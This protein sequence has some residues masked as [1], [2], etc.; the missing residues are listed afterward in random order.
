MRPGNDPEKRGNT[1]LLS[2]C[3]AGRGSP[4]RCKDSC[5]LRGWTR[6][7][8][9]RPPDQPGDECL[10]ILDFLWPM[11]SFCW[12]SASR[13]GHR[14]QGGLHR[15]RHVL[16]GASDGAHN[17][18]GDRSGRHQDRDRGAGPGGA[19]ALRQ[20][21][22]DAERPI[23]ALLQLL[24]GAGCRRRSRLGDAR[25]SVGMAIPGSG[26]L[27]QRP[28]QERQL[29]LAER[30]A[31]AADLEAALGREVRLA[32]DANCFVLSE[33]TDGAAAGAASGVRRDRRHRR[34]RRRVW[35][36][37]RCWA[38]PMAWRGMGPN[39]CPRPAPKKWPRR[40]PAI[41]ASAAAWKLWCS[42]PGLAAD[43]MRMAAAEARRRRNRRPRMRPQRTRR[44]GALDWTV[45]PA[46]LRQWSI[47]WIPM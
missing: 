14:S 43:F 1:G 24:A 41:A 44:D 31:A 22:P 19:V 8:C 4:R 20:R 25:A 30:Q 26:K 27:R 47:F 42:G 39:P 28:D 6:P 2:P 3:L 38:A 12:V 33:A 15:A 32:N 37:A 45:S 9:G 16:D 36:M 23:T 13:G 5:D 21:L 40:R 29:H 35:W 18:A 46:A 7:R 10:A 34:G 17:S 11:R